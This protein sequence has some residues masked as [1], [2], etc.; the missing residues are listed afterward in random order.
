MLETIVEH[1]LC[2]LIAVPPIQHRAHPVGPCD[3]TTILLFLRRTAKEGMSP[4]NPH[5][6]SVPACK[7]LL[8]NM[9]GI[10]GIVKDQPGQV[11]HHAQHPEFLPPGAVLG[12]GEGRT[13]ETRGDSNDT[14]RLSMLWKRTVQRPHGLQDIP[15]AL[16]SPSLPNSTAGDP[17]EKLLIEP[18]TIDQLLQLIVLVW[19]ATLQGNDP[20]TGS[21]VEIWDDAVK[22]R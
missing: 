15:V 5:H 8:L 12:Q 3:Y 6:G 16:P 7:R 9:G 21:M 2:Y 4:A 17:V 22:E 11:I 20:D 18:F 13:I 14:E 10:V 19:V 1:D